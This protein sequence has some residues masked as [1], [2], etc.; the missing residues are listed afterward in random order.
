MRTDTPQ[1]ATNYNLRIVMIRK[2]TP[3]IAH[4]FK[5]DTSFARPKQLLPARVTVD[6]HW[7]SVMTDLRIVSVVNVRANT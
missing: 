6:D 2:Y 4:P 5:P 7:S 1:A 3:L